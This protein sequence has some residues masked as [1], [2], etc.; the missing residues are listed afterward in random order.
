MSISQNNAN[1]NNEDQTYIYI[2]ILKDIN[3]LIT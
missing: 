1:I 3:Q 2:L